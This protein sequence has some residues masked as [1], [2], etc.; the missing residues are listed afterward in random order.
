MRQ[1]PLMPET[2][3]GATLTPCRPQGG[4][5]M[6]DKMTREEM[7]RVM[8]RETD[9]AKRIGRHIQHQM[10]LAD[11]TAELR[12]VCATCKYFEAGKNVAWCERLRILTRSDSGGI[13]VP[14]DG[15]GFCH[16]HQP[17]EEG[18]R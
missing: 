1:V 8:Q 4:T 10:D 14:Q 7:V 17:R 15:S 6:A 3:S 2:I 5:L 12:K 11:I 13:D 16:H 9:N 18:P